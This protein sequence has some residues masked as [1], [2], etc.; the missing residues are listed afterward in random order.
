[1][2]KK[3]YANAQIMLIKAGGDCPGW[4]LNQGARVLGGVV[5]PGG[6]MSGGRLSYLRTIRTITG[7][8]VPCCKTDKN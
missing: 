3:T 2:D 5:C 4:S 8:F 7:R 6:H 1:M